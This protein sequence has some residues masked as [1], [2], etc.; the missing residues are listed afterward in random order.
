MKSEPFLISGLVRIAVFGLP[1]PCIWEGLSM[2]QWTDAQLAG[3]VWEGTGR[4]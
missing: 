2:H 3:G 4:V 1:L